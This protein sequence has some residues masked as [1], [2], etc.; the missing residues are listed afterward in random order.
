MQLKSII[1][2]SHIVFGYSLTKVLDDV[3]FDV[4]EGEFMIL[5][6]QNGS[7]KTTLIKIILG[8]LKTREGS[9]KL[10][11]TPIQS[12]TAWDQIGYMPQNVAIT[13]PFFPGTV[14]EIVSLGLLSKKR[15]PKMITKNDKK[16]VLDMLERMH[17]EDLRHRMIGE[18]SGGQQQRVFLA[19]AFITNPK[20]LILDEP[21]NALDASIR[22]EFFQFLHEEHQKRKTTIILITHDTSH[23]DLY[24]NTLLYLDTKII[25]Y[26]PI[27]DFKKRHDASI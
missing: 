1:S 16:I 2:I 21:S 26:G 18:L 24:A 7:G 15:F 10:F 13:N 27:A 5:A 6:G 9:V 20:L 8:L 12:F 19:R 23:I 17:I 25:Y 14:E 3:S 11:G 22:K 4:R